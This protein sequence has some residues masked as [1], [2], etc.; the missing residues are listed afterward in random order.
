[1]VEDDKI[2]DDDSDS[3]DRIKNCPSCTKAKMTRTPFRRRE[4]RATVP[5]HIVWSDI[6]GPLPTRSIGG[7]R[8]FMT[9]IDDAT[10]YSWVYFLRH[11]SEAAATFQKFDR[12]TSIFFRPRSSNIVRIWRTDNAKEF[13]CKE[14][15]QFCSEHGIVH[16]TSIPYNPE[17]MGMAE[18]LNRTLMESSESMRFHSGHAKSFWAEAVCTANYLRNRSPTTTLDNKTPYEAFFGHRPS[19]LKLRVFGCRCWVYIPAQKRKKTRTKSQTS[20]LH[21]I[22]WTTK[23]L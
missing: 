14:I 22:F 3:E 15:Q 10:S 16:Q 1:M 5:L 2:S 7:N 6:C 21:W 17:Q 12:E 23:G 11:K 9:F 13:L 20:H 4:K 18:R 19:A 8:Y